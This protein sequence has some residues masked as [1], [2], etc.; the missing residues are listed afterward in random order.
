MSATRRHVTKLTFILSQLTATYRVDYL[1]AASFCLGDIVYTY[2]EMVALS[3]SSKW[4]N[5][6]EFGYG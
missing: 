6:R 2:F 4:G 3:R 1:S 5:G